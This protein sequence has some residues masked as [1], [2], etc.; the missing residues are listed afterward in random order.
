MTAVRP[1]EVIPGLVVH[2]DTGVLRS[3]GGSETN[4]TIDGGNGRAVQ[5]PHYFLVLE[6]SATGTIFTAVP[7][8][9]KAAPGSECL[10]NSAKSG[11]ADKWIGQSTYFSRWQHWRIP[12]TSIEAASVDEESQPTD[13]RGYAMTDMSRLAN[14]L[15]WQNHNANPYRLV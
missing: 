7:L 1:A 10:D 14:I 15:E 5:D 11:F 8:F 2:L 6:V 12:L 3:L 13:R 9:S 4:A